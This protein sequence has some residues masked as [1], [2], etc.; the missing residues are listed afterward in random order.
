M[1]ITD[2]R[3]DAFIDKS[4]DFA[5]PILAHLRK[6]VHTGCPD[7]EEAIKW[8]MPAFLY[9]GEILCHMAAFKA[10]AVFGFWKGSLVVDA[11]K[12]AAKAGAPKAEDGMGQFGKLTSRK[13]LPGDKAML[14]YI[15]T[16]MRLT[17]EGVK[18][19][20]RGK[21]AKPKPPLETPKYFLAA[22][23]KDKRAWACFQALAP[24]HKREYVEWIKEAKTDA[25][26]DS[27]L[28]TAVEWMA[29]GK[30]RMW[31]YKK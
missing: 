29:E 14:G 13:D 3:I 17:D 30:P 2:P 15:K 21:N 31:K 27:R 8:G 26:R 18:S 1:G 9:K 5:K 10:H 22:V 4:A 19:P 24:S 28:A 20:T 16:A 25:T 11:A 6:L 23:K 12:A 7:A